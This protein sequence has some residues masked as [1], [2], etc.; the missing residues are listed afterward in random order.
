[1]N[2][3]KKYNNFIENSECDQLNNWILTKKNTS[4]FQD[5][6]MNG[7][8]STTRYSEPSSF[9]FP[10]LAYE[11]QKKI[12]ST[13]KFK[14]Y[15]LPPYKDGMVASHALPKDTCYEHTDPIWIE[16]KVTLHCNVALSNFK[17]GEPFIDG[18]SIDFNKG[19]LLCYPV[20][21]I[22]H[23]S[24]EVLGKNS[25]NIWIFGFCLPTQETLFLHE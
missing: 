13:F 17:G 23:G 7:Y 3:Y 15:T 8:R 19:D 20:S 10:K 21:L 22:P 2:N 12:I 18:E 4:I 24:K 25:R 14:D 5:A 6:N 16:N 11:I 1:M 9:D